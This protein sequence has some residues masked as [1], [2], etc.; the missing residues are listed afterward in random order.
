MAIVGFQSGHDRLGLIKILGPLHA[1]RWI[2]SLRE[3]QLVNGEARR[4]WQF[5][6]DARAPE[7]HRRH[8]VFDQPRKMLQRR[9]TG[10]GSPNTLRHTIHTWH[11]RQGV[12]QAQIDAAAE[13]SS[14][15]GSGANY[16]HLR[17]EY[18][19]EFI[20]STEAFWEEVGQHTDSHLRYQRDTKMGL[21][22]G[23]SL[24]M[25]C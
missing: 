21:V 17:P 18:L 20:R 3:D 9:S 23:L 8:R 2:A 11:Q 1:I 24:D 13:H 6:E 10:I 12:P 15:R 14:E 25:A 7:H 5:H 22:A 4:L 16:T 19:R